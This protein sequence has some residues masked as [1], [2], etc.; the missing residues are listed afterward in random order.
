MEWVVGVDGELLVWGVG[1]VEGMSVFDMGC[2]LFVEWEVN[3][4]G[5]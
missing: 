5:F 4:G 2:M 3:E 1:G